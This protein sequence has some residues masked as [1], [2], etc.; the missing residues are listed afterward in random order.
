LIHL[1]DFMPHW[2]F[3]LGAEERPVHIILPLLFGGFAIDRWGDSCW[4]GDALPLHIDQ[5]EVPNAGHEDLEE[6]VVVDARGHELVVLEELLQ[7]H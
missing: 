7:T 2:R 1:L 5:V 6:V 3:V 4:L